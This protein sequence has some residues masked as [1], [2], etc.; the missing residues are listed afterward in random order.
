MPFPGLG[1]VLNIDGKATSVAHTRKD[2][3]VLQKRQG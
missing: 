1:Y 2:I 3:I